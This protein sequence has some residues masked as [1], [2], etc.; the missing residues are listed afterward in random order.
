MKIIKE[1]ERLLKEAEFYA[2]PKNKMRPKVRAAN[3][4]RIGLRRQEIQ[5]EHEATA[6]EIAFN[7]L[8]KDV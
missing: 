2:D 7:K 1:L 6:M 5:T 4:D 3:L 8:K